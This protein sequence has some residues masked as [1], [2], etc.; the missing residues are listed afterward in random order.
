MLWDVSLLL[1][2]IACT[3]LA[4]LNFLGHPVYVIFILRLVYRLVK[5]FNG[6][7][8]SGVCASNVICS[9][10]SIS[11]KNRLLWEK[12]KW[13]WKS[14]WKVGRKCTKNVCF[15]GKRG[16]METQIAMAINN[17]VKRLWAQLKRQGSFVGENWTL[18]A[19]VNK[20]V[21]RGLTLR[22]AHW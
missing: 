16:N 2:R 15:D 20:R 17:E 5:F 1:S 3:Y 12:A 10:V 18:Q 22:S 19:S 8:Y 21:I 4:N 7:I 9:P 6:C 14:G 11:Q 13:T